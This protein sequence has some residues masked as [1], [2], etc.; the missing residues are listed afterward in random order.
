MGIYVYCP[1]KSAGAQALSS[2]LGATR[3]RLFDGL[4]FWDKGKI[5]PLPEEGST[6]VCWGSHLPSIKGYLVLN[7]GQARIKTKD[8]E[9]R[10]LA[11]YTTSVRTVTPDW[12]GIDDTVIGRKRGSVSGNDLLIPTKN[13]DFFV[14][15]E[16]FVSEYR[17]FMALGNV[18]AVGAKVPRS[19]FK[20][21]DAK[22]WQPD[23][24]MVHPWVR[25][26]M[27]GWT[28]KYMKKASAPFGLTSVATYA[29]QALSLQFGYVDVG[30]NTLGTF[31]V[32]SVNSAP[33]LD[34]E[35]LPLYVEKI[36]GIIEKVAPS[37][38]K[39]EPVEGEIVFHV[40]VPGDFNDV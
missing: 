12:G 4:N 22:D 5:L 8:K 10:V 30:K 29:M 27:G 31:S 3:L 33:S 39:Q 40:A 13:P 38:P 25:S 32:I 26:W 11:Q 18:V 1:K 7:G 6:I 34:E 2:E 28:I 23:S 21:V 17:V 16:N 36:K 35:T 20:K 15:K 37:P 14:I 19:G 9:L 24:G